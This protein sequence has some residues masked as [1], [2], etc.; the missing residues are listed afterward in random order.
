MVDFGRIFKLPAPDSG[1]RMQ[2]DRKFCA[3]IEDFLNCTLLISASGEY[4]QPVWVALFSPGKAEW[5]E[6]L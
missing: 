6:P 2:R 1:F 3:Y 5:N 4:N